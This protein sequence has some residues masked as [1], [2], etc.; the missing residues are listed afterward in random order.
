MIARGMPFR[1][2]RLAI[3]EVKISA[4]DINRPLGI[5]FKLINCVFFTVLMWELMLEN[6]CVIES[7]YILKYCIFSFCLSE[8]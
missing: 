3:K 7:P 8:N 1:C 5:V 4:L 2:M 6:S